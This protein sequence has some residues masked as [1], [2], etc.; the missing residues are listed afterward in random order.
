MTAGLEDTVRRLA[1]M[2]ERCAGGPQEWVAQELLEAER[3][4][5]EAVRRLSALVRSLRRA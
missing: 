4:V 1:A 3:S 2:A 5:A